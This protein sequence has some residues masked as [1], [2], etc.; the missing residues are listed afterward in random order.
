MPSS[1][2]SCTICFTC[3]CGT[4]SMHATHPI[5]RTPRIAKIA[6]FPSNKFLAIVSSQVRRGN[7]R[8]ASN[9]SSK[10][11][12]QLLVSQTSSCSAIQVSSQ[13]LSVQ[14]LLKRIAVAASAPSFLGQLRQHPGRNGATRVQRRRTR[15]PERVNARSYT[16]SVGTLHQQGEKIQSQKSVKTAGTWGLR[17]Q[18]H[19]TSTCVV[20]TN[21]GIKGLMQFANVS[22]QRVSA[23][24][25]TLT[26]LQTQFQF[27]CFLEQDWR[28]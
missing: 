4:T 14:L 17:A 6:S 9:V 24:F 1:T 25:C 18:T 23:M 27:R 2:R 7:Q 10:L 16:G 8:I 3:W 15:T 19:Q 13:A 28:I 20:I 12:I 5:I 22:R 21:T 11:V 26:T